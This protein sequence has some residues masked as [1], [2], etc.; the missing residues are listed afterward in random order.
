[1]AHQRDR[2]E[3]NLAFA[4][5]V[6]DEMYTD[7]AAKLEDEKEMDDYQREILEKAL[8]FYE[9]FALPQSRDPQVR[10]EAAQAGLRVGRIRSRLGQTDAA[11][12]AYRQ[13]LDILSGL[14]SEHPDRAGL[15]RLLWPR[16]T[17]S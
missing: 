2:A 5:Q 17:K 8:R 3:R 10:L 15:S 1:M 7:V 16:R 12:Q 9:R 14:V 11:E 4:R 13:A 6:V